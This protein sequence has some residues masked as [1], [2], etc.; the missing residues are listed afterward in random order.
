LYPFFVEVHGKDTRNAQEEAWKCAACS[1]HREK[2]LV[3]KLGFVG[4]GKGQGGVRFIFKGV[5]SLF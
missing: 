4:R 2:R 3:P 1:L 5:I